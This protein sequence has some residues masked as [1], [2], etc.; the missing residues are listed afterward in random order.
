MTLLIENPKRGIVVHLER[1]L[2][3]LRTTL[4]EIALKPYLTSIVV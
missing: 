1:V 3:S 2:T 4:V